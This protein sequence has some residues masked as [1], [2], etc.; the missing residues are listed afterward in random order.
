MIPSILPVAVAFFEWKGWT[1][2]NTD[3]PNMIYTH[4]QG[5]NGQWKLFVVAHPEKPILVCYSLFP[6]TIEPTEHPKIFELLS[7]LNDGL[8]IGN[9]EYSYEHREIRYKTSLDATDM[10]ES[11][12]ICNSMVYYNLT[13]MDQ[14]FPVL[15]KFIAQKPPRAN[16][17]K[18]SQV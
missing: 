4:F 1:V 17:F 11:L 14:Y 10:P 5:N 15:E 6:K 2:L 12:S 18:E 7:Q 13:A 8:M 16:G 9:F 3:S